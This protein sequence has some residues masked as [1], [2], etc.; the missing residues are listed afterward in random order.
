[1]VALSE[2]A[3]DL[4]AGATGGGAEDPGVDVGGGGAAFA[5]PPPQATTEQEVRSAHKGKS[6]SHLM[7]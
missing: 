5:A 6:P 7:G 3:D 2:A 4:E 1:M